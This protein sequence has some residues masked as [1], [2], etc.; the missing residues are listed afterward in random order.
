MKKLTQ[1]EKREIGYQMNDAFSQ[2]EGSMDQLKFPDLAA[3]GQMMDSI[4]EKKR[5][6][7][8]KLVSMKEEIIK[9]GITPKPRPKPRK[10]RAKK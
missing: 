5:L 4:G 8:E 2:L 9:G 10:R 1:K 7:E 6:I 3:L